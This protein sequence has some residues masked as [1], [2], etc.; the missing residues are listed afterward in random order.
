MV[1]PPYTSLINRLPIAEGE[2]DGIIALAHIEMYSLI[3]EE[4][5]VEAYVVIAGS[6]DDRQM[7]CAAGNIHLQV[8]RPAYAKNSMSNQSPNEPAS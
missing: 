8:S 3:G 2:L 4:R 7:A 6:A 1:P 5:V